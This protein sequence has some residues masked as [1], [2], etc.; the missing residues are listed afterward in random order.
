MGIPPNYW[1]VLAVA[2]KAEFG[3]SNEITLR[4]II[5]YIPL[6]SKPARAGR[7]GPR[8]AAKEIPLLPGIIFI[9]GPPWGLSDIPKVKGFLR[10]PAGD[11][12]RCT[13]RQLNRFRAIVDSYL[14]DCRADIAKGKKA[15]AKPKELVIK[16]FSDLG[17][18]QVIQRLF[19]IVESPGQR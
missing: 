10:N 8:N 17:S 15:P 3:V 13:E 4:Q 19:G 16:D 7:K 1:H 5:W 11:P 6:I 2:S 9:H 18:L 14:E 12:F